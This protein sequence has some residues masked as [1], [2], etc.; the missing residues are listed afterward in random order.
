MTPTQ[1]LVPLAYTGF[2]TSLDQLNNRLF[3]LKIDPSSLACYSIT[4]GLTAS[5]SM[6]FLSQCTGGFCVG[7][8]LS[9]FILQNKKYD[10]VLLYPLYA[11][12][13][14]GT[15]LTIRTIGNIAGK[16]ITRGVMKQPVTDHEIE[17]LNVSAIGLGISAIIGVTNLLS[18]AL[19]VKYFLTYS[20]K[21]KIN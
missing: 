14:L 11:A 17:K 2:R 8:L 10:T 13:V 21:I 6:R 9:N 4:A 16:H 12:C 3:N 20:E 1:I 5:V 15:T 19:A 18:V 7:S